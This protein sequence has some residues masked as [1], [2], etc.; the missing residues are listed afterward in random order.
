MTDAN[1][2]SPPVFVACTIILFPAMAVDVKVSLK[3]S[4]SADTIGYLWY[5]TRGELTRSKSSRWPPRCRL[6]C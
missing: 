3:I 2:R 5:C 6:E 1:S 4:S